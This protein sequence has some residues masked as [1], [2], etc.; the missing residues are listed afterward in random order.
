MEQKDKNHVK[1][2]YQ[3]FIRTRDKDSWNKALPYLPSGHLP[4]LDGLVSGGRHYVV[5]IWHDGY[6][7]HIVIVAWKTQS[8]LV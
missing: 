4:H 5:T 3:V 6:R 8:S 2:H 7:R 1:L